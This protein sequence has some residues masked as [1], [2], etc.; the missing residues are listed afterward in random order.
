MATSPPSPSK[1]E[2]L[3]ALNCGSS[4][5]KLKL[6]ALHLHDALSSPSRRLRRLSSTSSLSQTS[7]AFYGRPASVDLPQGIELLVAASV[8]LKGESGNRSATLKWSRLPAGSAVDLH[9]KITLQHTEIATEP[10]I[11]EIFDL[12]TKTFNAT[13]T[14][15]TS[16]STLTLSL[17]ALPPPDLRTSIRFIT[18]RVVHGAGFPHPYIISHNADEDSRSS[19]L[20]SLETL[21]ELAPLHNIVST[22]VIKLCIRMVPGADQL[23]LW[24]TQFHWTIPEEISTYPVWQPEAIQLPGGMPLRKWGFHGLSYSSVLRQVSAFLER[25]VSTLNLII[26]HLGSGASLCAIRAGKSLDTSMGLTPLEGLPGSTRAGSVDP[27]LSHHLK[28][29]PARHSTAS[30]S[31]EGGGGDAL[32]LSEQGRVTVPGGEGVQIDW[33]EWELNSKSG[34]L[35][36]AGTRDFEEIVARKDG[37]VEGCTPED[38]R[39]AKLAFDVFVDRILAYLGAYTF[40]ILAA[41]AAHVDALVFSGGIGEHSTELR[42][43]L[44][45]KLEHTPLALRSADGGHYG[46]EN[47]G[48]VRRILGPPRE[49][50][51]VGMGMSGAAGGGGNGSSSSMS[52]NTPKWSGEIVPGSPLGPG[53]SMPGSPRTLHGT[54][55]S[56]WGVPWLVAETD[57]ELECVRLSMPTIRTLWTST[58]ERE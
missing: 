5:L 12:L 50:E 58:P 53:A 55:C 34:W 24:D 16:T 39:K 4:S 26:A 18:H 52:M 9:D 57:E 11:Q 47:V 21:E 49:G 30:A 35:A 27:A 41:G 28:P 43:A 17:P 54:T 38:R 37:L 6:F 7:A 32:D 44:A 36:L 40:K 10:F 20:K 25:P 56:R 48:G 23:C 8:V 42:M 33:A 45:A 2:Y 29:D 3:L 46:S 51:R 19:Q 15:T 31:G 13:R 22:R 14:S 1:Q